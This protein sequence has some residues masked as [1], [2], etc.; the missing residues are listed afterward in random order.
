MTSV[1]LAKVFMA[2]DSIAVVLMAIS[3]ICLFDSHRPETF[4]L[5][6]GGIGLAAYLFVAPIA[7]GN[8][9]RRCLGSFGIRLGLPIAIAL[10][11]VYVTNRLSPGRDDNIGSLGPPLMAAV[12][13]LASG[14]PLAI[15][16]HW[17]LWR[18][19]R[20]LKQ[21]PAS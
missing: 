19:S 14:I 10:T 8:H 9:W 3:G 12:I 7:L 15:I 5:V 17:W 11:A 1:R 18:P 20:Q 16:I 2:I 13:G 6:H 4:E 21:D